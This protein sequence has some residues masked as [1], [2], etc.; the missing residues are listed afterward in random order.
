MIGIKIGVVM[1]LGMRRSWPSWPS[2]LLLNAT[3]M[4][5][6]ANAGAAP[7][8]DRLIRGADRHAGHAP[9]APFRRAPPRPTAISDSI[10]PGGTACSARTGAQPAA[11][12]RGMTI[13]I[14]HVSGGRELR[15]D[16]MLLQPFRND[17]GASAPGER[18]Q[19]SVWRWLWLG[20]TVFQGSELVVAGA[21]AFSRFI[22]VV[23]GLFVF[24]SFLVFAF[25]LAVAS[26]VFLASPPPNWARAGAPAIVSIANVAIAARMYLMTAGLIVRTP[27]INCSFYHGQSSGKKVR[28]DAG[29]R[30]EF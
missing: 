19:V 25:I 1:A 20:G 7:P 6:H 4:F 21:C 29:N 18:C 11:G 16:R 3:S 17:A 14:D 10:C 2:R 24:R 15:L 27:E 22:V 13:G 26:G 12:H 30:K 9:R 28:G 23:I 5:N 8:L